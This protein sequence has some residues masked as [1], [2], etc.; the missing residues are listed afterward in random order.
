MPPSSTVH[1]GQHDTKYVTFELPLHAVFVADG[2][3]GFML[4]P[5]RSVHMARH[6]RGSYIVHPMLSLEVSTP[7]KQI[8]SLDAVIH[9]QE[10]PPRK[11]SVFSWDAAHP[12]HATRPPTP[13][14]ASRLA[15]AMS[16]PS[17]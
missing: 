3:C 6:T 15:Q 5:A 17:R 2:I 16:L 4:D 12:F 8:N 9:M 14:G 13:H 11:K 7:E 1:G 10:S